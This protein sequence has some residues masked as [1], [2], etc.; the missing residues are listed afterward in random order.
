MYE[1]TERVKKMTDILYTDVVPH[2]TNNEYTKYPLSV[3]YCIYT[4]LDCIVNDM[5]RHL[6]IIMGPKYVNYDSLQFWDQTLRVDNLYTL[7]AK[8]IDRLQ[9][10]SHMLDSVGYSNGYRPR[11]DIFQLSGTNED[12]SVLDELSNSGMGIRIINDNDMRESGVVTRLCSNCCLFKPMDELNYDDVE[13]YYFT[14]E[15]MQ[16]T[17]SVGVC[18]VCK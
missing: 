17:T 6:G 3:A 5:I 14:N 12:D 9:K 18:R 7:Y 8:Y 13:L 15:D 4:S 2:Y 1:L 10:N 16:D 11:I